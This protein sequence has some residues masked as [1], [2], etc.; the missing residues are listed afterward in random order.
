MIGCTAAGTAIDEYF[1]RKWRGVIG[2][3]ACA[4]AAFGFWLWMPFVYGKYM[5]D[6]G[7]MDWLAIGITGMTHTEGRARQIDSSQN[8]G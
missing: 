4:L 3:I 7:I 8:R 2:F 5:H 1:P 6:R